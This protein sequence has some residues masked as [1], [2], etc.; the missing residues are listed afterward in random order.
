[1]NA[2]KRG[3]L[4]A[5]TMAVLGAAQTA[6]A[7]A[8][9]G[10]MVCATD[11]SI[12]IPDVQVSATLVQ[13]GTVEGTATTDGAGAFSFHVGFAGHDYVLAPTGTPFLCPADGSAV[14]LGDLEADAEVCTPPPPPPVCEV[15]YPA[16]YAVPYCPARPLGN[17]KAECEKFGLVVLDKDD[18]T[19]GRTW[20]ASQTA[21]LAIV[22]AGGCY[23]AVEGVTKGDILSSPTTQG[24]SH[25]TYCTCPPVD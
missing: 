2:I 15:T 24:I 16:G 23:R 10:R 7:C 17:P 25:V 4:A 11:A 19:T 5:L 12:G 13:T 20:I 3:L 18:G 22:K 1:M 21:A 8:V 14:H 9:D 6:E